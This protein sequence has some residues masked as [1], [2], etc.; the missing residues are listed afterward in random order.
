MGA[1]ACGLRSSVRPRPGAFHDDV[2]QP[3]IDQ[4]EDARAAVDMRDD[5]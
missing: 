2:F 4:L 3:V 5:R 1:N